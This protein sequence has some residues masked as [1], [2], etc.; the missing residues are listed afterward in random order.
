MRVNA[1]GP[2]LRIAALMAPL[3]APMERARLPVRVPL[4]FA[5]SM[6]DVLQFRSVLTASTNRAALAFLT[7][8]SLPRFV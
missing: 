6:V 4:A 8:A 3:L 7:P 5:R 2:P 1:Q